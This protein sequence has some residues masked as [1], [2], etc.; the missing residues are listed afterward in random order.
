MRKLI[1]GLNMTLDGYCDHTAGIADEE[2]HE[3]YNDVL[4]NAGTLI[5]GRITYQLME[6]YWPTI[7]KDP[8]G[9]KPMDDFA[10]LIDDISKIVYSQTLN[11][12]SWKNSTLKKEITREDILVLKQQPGKNILVGSPSL[13]VALSN[14]GVVDE[15]QIG[16]QPIILGSGLPLFKNIRERID[17]NLLHSKT[18][19]CG[20]MMLYYAPGPSRVV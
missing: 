4:R 3:H 17:L 8:T 13:I 14:L 12:V 11:D 9:N 6:S 2:I 7:V 10:V 5:Y 18:F 20:A 1:A 19:K 15:Y 16:V